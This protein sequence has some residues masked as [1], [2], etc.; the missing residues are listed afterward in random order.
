M[1]SYSPSPSLSTFLAQNGLSS[2]TSNF[3]S[4]S[5]KLTLDNLKLVN[6]SDSKELNELCKELKITSFSTKL[7]LRNAISKLKL[8]S[9]K[10]SNVTKSTNNIRKVKP[11]SKSYYS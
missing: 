3:N 11:K 10:I 8:S 2:L 4:L 5:I 1:S 6:L 7:R 9:P